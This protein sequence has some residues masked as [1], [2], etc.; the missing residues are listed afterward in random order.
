[1]KFNKSMFDKENTNFTGLMA[2][3][4]ILTWMIMIIIIIFTVI[5]HLNGVVI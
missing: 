2:L 5:D 4:G 1:M 3:T